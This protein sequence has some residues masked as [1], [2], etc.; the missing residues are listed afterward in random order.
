MSP[1]RIQ[2]RRTKGW[3][4]P[5]G[6]IYVGRPTRWGN[7][8]VVCDDLNDGCEH[9]F[10]MPTRWLAAVKFKHCYM[11]PLSSDPPVPDEDDIRRTLRDHDLACWCPLDEPCHA[12]VL[13][14]LANA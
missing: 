11:A 5:R 2:M 10:C 3:R 1:Q 14:E 13:F 12:D 8:F 9:E 4:K 7:P 6:A